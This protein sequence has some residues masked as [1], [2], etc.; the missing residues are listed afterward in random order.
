[1]RRDVSDQNGLEHGA[2]LLSPQPLFFVLTFVLTD[3]HSSE[4]T[5]ALI[6]FIHSIGS[7]VVSDKYSLL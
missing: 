4:V 3:K 2:A 5:S 6:C 1:M 7:I